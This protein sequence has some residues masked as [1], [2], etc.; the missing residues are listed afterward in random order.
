MMIHNAIKNFVQAQLLIEN[1]SKYW[2][3]ICHCFIICTFLYLC[4][5]LTG[6]SLFFFPDKL[7]I[8]D[9]LL[10]LCIAFFINLAMI[11]P[12]FSFAKKFFW[13]ILFFQCSS[14]II[15]SDFLDGA[16]WF[17]A[18]I[19]I[20]SNGLGFILLVSKSKKGLKSDNSSH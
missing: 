10:G 5:F 14:V 16:A 12:L 9:Y 20:I 17:L 6:L 18:L 13:F 15:Y 19:G 2:L 8:S 7:S 3:F 11:L 4:Y 1:K